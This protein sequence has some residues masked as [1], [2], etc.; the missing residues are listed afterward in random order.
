MNP[1]HKKAK[2]QIE[3]LSLALSISQDHYSP[4]NMPGAELALFERPPLPC[5]PF[6]LLPV[7][8]SHGDGHTH[9]QA[10]WSVTPIK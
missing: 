7:W 3:S 1:Q 9:R 6:I 5:L 2:L 10:I 4:H 8:E